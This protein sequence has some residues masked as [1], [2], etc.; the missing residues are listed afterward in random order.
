MSR[1]FINVLSVVTTILGIGV[2]LVSGFVQ[3]KKLEQ[4]VV[5]EVGKAI[6]KNV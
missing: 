2:T 4:M 5:K 1:R 3:D 6:A